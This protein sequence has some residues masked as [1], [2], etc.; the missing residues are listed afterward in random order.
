LNVSI[1]VVSED[2]GVT[3]SVDI[4]SNK[5]EPEFLVH[6]AVPS[7]AVKVLVALMRE[8]TVVLDGVPKPPI[9]YTE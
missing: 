8:D 4:P 3:V 6:T 2:D 9:E 7:K 1:K 5:A